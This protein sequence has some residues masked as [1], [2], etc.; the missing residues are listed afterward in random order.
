M[1]ERLGETKNLIG[2]RTHV[3][4]CNALKLLILLYLAIRLPSQYWRIY[5]L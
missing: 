4:V 1:F 5:L 3:S 2:F